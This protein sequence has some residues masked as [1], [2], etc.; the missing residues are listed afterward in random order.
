MLAVPEKA[1]CDEWYLAG[2]EWTIARHWEMRYQEI[3]GL[4]GDLLAE[5][6]A[7]FHSPRM[8]RALRAFLE[9]CRESGEGL[10]V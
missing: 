7:G 2:G 5:F 3:E 6:V 4:R 9:W 10:R 8:D 1:L